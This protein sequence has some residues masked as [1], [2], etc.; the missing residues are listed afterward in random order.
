MNNPNPKKKKHVRTNKQ[1]DTKMLTIVTFISH[2]KERIF[3]KFDTSRAV[4]L[5]SNLIITCSFIHLKHATE[6]KKAKGKKDPYFL[7]LWH[8]R[9]LKM[10]QTT[11]DEAYYRINHCV[12]RLFSNVVSRSVGPT[13]QQKKTALS[14]TT[15]ME[16]Q[17]F[18]GLITILTG[19]ASL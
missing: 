14:T 8:D 5:N 15:G 2:K 19:G 1:K 17:K 13:K 9:N 6:Q 12:I 3:F 16:L 11:S 4:H 10:V 18:L 7:L